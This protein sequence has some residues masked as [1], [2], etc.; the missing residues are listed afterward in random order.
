MEAPSK[1]SQVI[2]ITS[3]GRLQLQSTSQK[4]VF[5]T[6]LQ[7]LF[8]FFPA[9]LLALASLELSDS[10]DD[11]RLICTCENEKGTCVNQTCSGYVCFYSW[12]SNYEERGCFS[13]RIYME[14]CSSAGP[15][16]YIKC[17]QND[18]CNALITVPPGKGQYPE[19][20]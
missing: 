18:S 13:K 19:M 8:R 7:V 14:Q 5:L 12:L 17:C 20:R 3:H 11:E 1:R 10:K 16:F 9:D 15:Q 6:M 4:I 2:A